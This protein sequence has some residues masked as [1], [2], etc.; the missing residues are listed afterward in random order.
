[1]KRFLSFFS[2]LVFIVACDKPVVLNTLGS[3]SGV[4]IDSKTVAPLAGVRVSLSPTGSSQVTG[5]DGTFLFDRLQVQEYTLVAT[6]DGYKAEQ[7]K[8]SVNPGVTSSAHFTLTTTSGAF[9]VT[10]AE[11]DFGNTTTSMRVQVRNASGAPTNFSTKTSNN[12]LTVS[13]ETGTITQSDYLTVLVSREGLSPGDYSGDVTIRYDGETLIIPVKMSIMSNTAANI[14]LESIDEVGAHTAKAKAA[15]TSI[16]AAAVTKMGICWSASNTVP[17]INDESTNQGDAYSPC[18]FSALLSGLTSETTYY[19]RAYAQNA[20]GITYSDQ[21]LSFTTTSEQSGNVDDTGVAVKQG[22]MFYLSFDGSTVQDE[23]DNELEAVSIGSPSFL[24]D[25]PSGSGMSLALNGTKGQYISI[26][27]PLFD[28]LNNYSIAFWAKDFGTGS[29][30]SALNKN[31]YAS[32]NRPKVYLSATGKLIFDT[33]GRDV[34]NSQYWTPPFSYPLTDI[35][36]GKWHHF[37]VTL[38]IASYRNAEKKLYVDG[39]FVDTIVDDTCDISTTKVIIGGNAEGGYAVSMTTKIDNV[40]FYNRTLS[41]EE[42]KAIYDS[43][44]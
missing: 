11:L 24:T 26:P 3:I 31:G 9:S 30:V 21:C 14:S 16:G 19:C 40:R 28:G 29:F 18:D 41:K 33:Y 27:Y 8:V 7:Q 34:T 5:Q 17:T 37:C 32:G 20:Y 35:Q 23:S 15:L 13:P 39:V 38:D 1:M 44:K 43:E 25:T 12:W 36:S 42:A 6:K 4:V 22:L 10:P 2:V